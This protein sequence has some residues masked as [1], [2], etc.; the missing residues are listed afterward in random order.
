MNVKRQIYAVIAASTLLCIYS[1]LFVHILATMPFGYLGRWFHWLTEARPLFS[2][3][4]QTAIISA[5]SFY[6]ASIVERQERRLEKIAS[7]A[8]AT[9]PPALSASCIDDESDPTDRL[10]CIVGTLSNELR[11]TVERAR[12]TER[13]ILQQGED[14]KNE[15]EC[16]KKSLALCCERSCRYRKHI[17]TLLGLSREGVVRL[18]AEMNVVFANAAFLR[19]NGSESGD[20]LF[21]NFFDVV[22]LGMD[23]AMTDP[24][25]IRDAIEGDGTETLDLVWLASAADKK[26]PMSVVICP[27]EHQNKRTGTITV[28]TDLTESTQNYRL[29]RALFEHTAEGFV[30]FSDDF[31]PID[32]N[33]A[34]IKLFGAVSKKE[35]VKGFEKFSKE[36]KC[37]ISLRESFDEVQQLVDR[38]GSASFEWLHI[39]AEG[40]EMPCLVTIFYVWLGESKFY[41]S[42]VRDLTAQKQAEHAMQEKMQYVQDILDS[43]PTAIVVVQDGVIKRFNGVSAELLG[44]SIGKMS[45]R[46]DYNEAEHKRVLEALERNEKLENWPLRMLGAD[47]REFDTLINLYR[48]DYEGKDAVLMWITDVTEITRA[49]QTAEAASAAKSLFLATMSHEIRTPMNAIIG[50][51]HLLLQTELGKKQ[52]DYVS[53]ILS[54]GNILLSLINDILDL[55]KIEAGQFAL[56]NAPFKI[57]NLIASVVDLIAYKADAKG[58][59]FEV[60][61]SPDVPAVFVGDALRLEQILLN[62]CSN[63]IKFTEEGYIRVEVSCERTEEIREGLPV[64]ALRFAVSDTGIGID[65]DRIEEA[66][67][68]FTQLDGSF[69]RAHEGSGLGLYIGRYLARCMDGDIELVGR[70]G[71]GTTATLSVLLSVAMDLEMLELSNANNVAEYTPTSLDDG[72]ITLNAPRSAIDARVL[73]VEDNEINQEIAAELL[74]Q[75]GATVETAENGAEAVEML[76]RADYDLVLMDIRMPIMDGLEATRKIRGELGL[77]AE[78]LPIIAVTAHAM[79][80]DRDASIDAGMNDHITKPLDPDTLYLKVREWTTHKATANRKRQPA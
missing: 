48:F 35:V 26:T 17:N 41:I 6:V 3:M 40:H 68:R 62:L 69:T 52:F 39:D 1:A 58:L 21:K 27:V 47:G 66:F 9:L 42:N 11:E 2:L 23:E 78:A 16:L 76:S 53:K 55:S 45:D 31:T 70:T 13:R 64:C 46:P 38:D 74:M 10:C 15:N 19:M 49:K 29:A 56:Y 30:F 73:L 12:C 20:I 14:L 71:G 34:I 32:C 36:Q 50:M 77:D 72:M 7:A 24:V 25:P 57:H 8:A 63:A 65:P 61:V 75:F 54:A 60:D 33:E 37:G 59:A 28:F 22:R 43:S 51:G 80:D 4:L 44:L 67:G 79:K 18:D 5:A